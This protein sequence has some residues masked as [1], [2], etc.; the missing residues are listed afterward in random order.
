M[1]FD[2]Q[3]FEIWYCP[4]RDIA[5]H[6][7]LVL[8]TSVSKPTRYLVY[9]PQLNYRIIYEANDY[10]SAVQWLSEDEYEFIE[11]REFPDDGYPLKTKDS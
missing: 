5:P 7:I 11:G 9:D 10:E 4:G 8:A 1:I 6:Y 2:D 3:W